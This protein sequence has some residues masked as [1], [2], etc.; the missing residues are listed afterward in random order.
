M[1][2]KGKEVK[3]N[4]ESILSESLRFHGLLTKADGDDSNSKEN[5]ELPDHLKTADFLFKKIDKHSD[6]SLPTMKMA[7]FKRKK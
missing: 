7:A 1:S 5:D 2:K 6:Q 3:D 4:F